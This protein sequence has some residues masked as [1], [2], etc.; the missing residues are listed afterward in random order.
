MAAIELESVTDR[1]GDTVAV[2][3]LDLAVRSGEVS[4]FPRPDGTGKTM[5]IDLLLDVSRSTEWGVT[6]LGL[7]VGTESVA[8]R[9]RE[10]SIDADDAEVDD[11]ADDPATRPPE[12]ARDAVPDRRPA[13]DRCLIAFERTDL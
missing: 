4:G 1:V 9:D 8:V 12:R 11:E 10:G 13:R 3:N 5:A 7:D 2:S 6:V